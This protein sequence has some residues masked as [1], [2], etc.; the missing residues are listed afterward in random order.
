MKDNN[1]NNDKILEKQND[2]I[3]SF[4]S[5]LSDTKKNKIIKKQIRKL[6]PNFSRFSLD[7]S[8]IYES[9]YFEHFY[10]CLSNKNAMKPNESQ[11]NILLSIY[12]NINDKSNSLNNSDFIEIQKEFYEYFYHEQPITSKLSFESINLDNLI[13]EQNSCSSISI[14]KLASEYSSKYDIKISKSKIYNILKYNLKYKYLKTSPKNIKSISI[15]SKK[16]NFFVIKIICRVLLLKGVIVYVDESGFSNKNNN[17]RKWRKKNEN[18]YQN[19]KKEEK[20]NLILAVSNKKIYGYQLDINPTNSKRFKSFMEN[21]IKNM[22]K[23]EI[24]ETVFFMDNLTSHKTLEMYKFY[25]ENKL[26]ILFNTP[27]I[28]SFNMIEYVF[29]FIKNITYK[30]LYSS[31]FEL[32]QAI[33]N[34]IESD[35]LRFTLEKLYKETLFNYINF[36]EQNKFMNLNN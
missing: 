27:Y 20:I 9:I 21:I 2:S 1:N 22:S 29:R 15:S 4:S 28:S 8:F 30:N 3:I 12:K 23:E 10:S 36:I 31:L 26:K 6:N 5:S 13:K 33:N 34:I 32:Q 16:Q 24:R 11:Y 35:K 19:I 7:S 18:C 25:K 17:F 14:R